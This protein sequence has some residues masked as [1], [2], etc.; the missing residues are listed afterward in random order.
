MAQG[1]ISGLGWCVRVYH[2]R[3][4]YR[5]N[6]VVTA[7]SK[8]A[9]AQARAFPVDAVERGSVT[10]KGLE[11]HQSVAALTAQHGISRSRLATGLADNGCAWLARRL[12]RGNGAI[13]HLVEAP[14]VQ[15]R[16]AAHAVRFPRHFRRNHGFHLA[17]R[18][19]VKGDAVCHRQETVIY[20]QLSARAH[21]QRRYVALLSHMR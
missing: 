21:I 19:D 7:A 13:P 8:L 20:Q 17:R 14:F 5:D 10:G 11:R 3:S 2:D 18:I 9:Q 16:A 4:D 15:H 12:D 1:A 6:V